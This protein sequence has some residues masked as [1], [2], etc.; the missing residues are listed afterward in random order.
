MCRTVV[1]VAV[2]SV[3]GGGSVTATVEEAMMAAAEE[4]D[5]GRGRAT[6]GRIYF[7]VQLFFSPSPP[8]PLKAKATVWLLS[9][10]PQTLLVDCCLYRFLIFHFCRANNIAAMLL[11]YLRDWGGVSPN[12]GTYKNIKRT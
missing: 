7:F 11:R 5:D 10:L 3:W 1:A 6:L 2:M 4:V 8:L 9:F 12:S